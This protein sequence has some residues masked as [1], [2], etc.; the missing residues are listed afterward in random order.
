MTFLYR[1][2]EGATKAIH[3]GME[4]LSNTDALILDMR[5]NGGGSP[6]TAVEL[7]SYFFEPNTPLFSETEGSNPPAKFSSLQ[8][9][10]PRNVTRPT[11]VLVSSRSASG[12]EGKPYILQDRH[13][14]IVIGERTWAGANAAYPYQVN[15]VLKITIPFGEIKTA[16]T[17]TNWEGTGVTPNVP[18][19]AGDALT[20]ARKMALVDLIKHTNDPAKVRL[21]QKALN[22][23][24]GDCTGGT[25]QS[26]CHSKTAV[27]N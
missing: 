9:I 20:V 13:R 2:E 17:N 26:D 16:L 8:N 4:F 6:K 14:A 21:L 15:A 23:V 22:E 19:P 1:P 11:Y 24:S 18:I 10:S 12:G 27:A 7:L 25:S 5:E 3:D